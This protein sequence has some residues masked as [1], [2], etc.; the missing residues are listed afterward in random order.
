M[1]K[2]KN[3]GITLLFI[4]FSFLIIGQGC[5]K[6]E[7]FILEE[8]SPLNLE[9]RISLEEEEVIYDSYG[10]YCNN[11]DTQFIVVSNKQSL[12]NMEINSGELESGDFIMIRE[13]TDDPQYSLIYIYELDENGV[14]TIYFL[15]DDL[16]DVNGVTLDENLIEGEINGTFSSETE[17]INV[18]YSISFVC[19]L[20]ESTELCE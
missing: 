11:G 16:S 13:G 7:E 15:S 18:N 8:V 4:I 2:T 6:N 19:G 5:K 20:M 12:L 17:E 10:S 1:N 9:I 14:N 3:Q